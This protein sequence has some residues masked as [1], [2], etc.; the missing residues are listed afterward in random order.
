MIENIL[1]R[2]QDAAAVAVYAVPDEAAGDQVMTALALREGAVF[3]PEAFGAF[4][5]RQPDLGTKMAPRYVRIVASMPTTATNKIHR[6]ALR[7]EGFRC[8]DPVWHGAPAG[9]TTA[10]TPPPWP[11]C[12]RRTSPTAVRTSWPADRRS[13]GAA[14]GPRAPPRVMV[15]STPEDRV[16]FSLSAGAASSV[17]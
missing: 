17:G 7:R 3:S 2:W 12:S 1:A 10:W 15:L 14:P 5:S 8:E 16:V 6:A 9:A 4:L 13:R 11:P